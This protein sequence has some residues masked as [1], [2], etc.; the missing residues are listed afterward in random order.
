MGYRAYLI[1]ASMAFLSCTAYND[2]PRPMILKSPAPI[3]KSLNYRLGLSTEISSLAVDRLGNSCYTDP[4]GWTLISVGWDGSE[5]FRFNL[6]RHGDQ[7]ITGGSES[8]WL[9]N[10]LDRKIRA[11]DKNGQPTAE[12]NYYGITATT[13]AVTTAGEIY[14][15]DGNNARVK[16]LDRQGHEIRSFQIQAEGDVVLRPGSISV[17]DSRNILALADG[18][19]GKVVFYNLYGT[20]QSILNIPVGNHPQAICFDYLG[21]IWTCQPELGKVVIY[22]SKGSAWIAEADLSLRKPYAVAMSSFGSGVVVE[23]GNLVFIK[24]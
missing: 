12:I 2:P 21:M 15:L 9:I 20:K 3:E 4:A 8:Y 24:F 18:R 17:D 1:I 22:S 5:M 11:F 7:L 23:D 14:L 13:G 6:T 19:R 10:F 16:V